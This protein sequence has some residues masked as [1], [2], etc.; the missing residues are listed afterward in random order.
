M[1]KPKTRYN[2]ENTFC[3]KTAVGN[4]KI[5]EGKQS[6]EGNVTEDRLKTDTQYKSFK[7]VLQEVKNN[8]LVG[9]VI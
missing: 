6:D 2:I 4:I 8:H 3:A 5:T 9:N 7:N 1:N